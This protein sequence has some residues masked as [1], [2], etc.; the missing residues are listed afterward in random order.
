MTNLLKYGDVDIGLPCKLQF[1]FFYLFCYSEKDCYA[2]LI[3]EESALDIAGLRHPCSRI[4][5]NIIPDGDAELFGIF[6]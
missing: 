3:I 4:E 6:L 5:A 2:E 1:F